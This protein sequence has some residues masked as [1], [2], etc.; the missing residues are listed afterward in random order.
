MSSRI[1]DL[2]GQTVVIIG[3]SSGIGL[4]T[5]RLVVA[6]GGSV[7]LGS[8]TQA[9]VEDAVE[10]LGPR[11]TGR[12]VDATSPESLA[13]FFEPLGA[14]DHLF[15]PAASYR[16]GSIRDLDLADA[17]SPFRAKFW[18]QYTAVKA[19]LPRLRETGSVVLI[20][21]AASARPPAP[22]AAYVAANSAIEGLGRG[23][24]FELAPIRVNTVSPGTVDGSLWRSRPDDVRE[25]A[26]AGYAGS[27]L[28]GRVAREEEIAHAVLY[29]MTNTFTTGSTL[30]TDG[31]YSYR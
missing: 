31:G 8:R 5:A 10:T 11:A 6:Q 30:F 22:A 7:V 2:D 18:P 23:L 26:F 17:E 24:A 20:S 14:V 3:G 16:T 4:A 25:A 19:A 15:V 12:T 27:S 13:E 29:L 21:G 28:L 1:S 9:K